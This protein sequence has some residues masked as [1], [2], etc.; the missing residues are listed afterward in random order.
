MKEGYDRSV[1]RPLGAAHKKM[2]TIF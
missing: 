2:L 1:L